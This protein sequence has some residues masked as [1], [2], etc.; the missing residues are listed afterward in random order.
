MVVIIYVVGGERV[1]GDA[2]LAVLPLA[3]VTHTQHDPRDQLSMKRDEEGL[4]NAGGRAVPLAV[5]RVRSGGT[6]HV[7]QVDLR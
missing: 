3:A 2:D 6:K 1:V 4:V 7:A 5:E